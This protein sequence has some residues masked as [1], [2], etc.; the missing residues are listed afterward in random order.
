MQQKTN[1]LFVFTINTVL[2]FEREVRK[3]NVNVK[4]NRKLK[5]TTPKYAT[6][7]KL[8]ACVNNSCSR[9]LIFSSWVQASKINYLKM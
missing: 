8:I 4:V 9:C 1:K 6:R 5:L 7:N 3:K 2:L